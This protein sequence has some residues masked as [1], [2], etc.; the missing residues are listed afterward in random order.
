MLK[1]DHSF[2]APNF[3]GQ[4]IALTMCVRCVLWWLPWLRLPVRRPHSVCWCTPA[5]TDNALSGSSRTL[6]GELLTGPSSSRGQRRDPA[7]SRVLMQFGSDESG[8]SHQLSVFPLRLLLEAAGFNLDDAGACGR[9]ACFALLTVPIGLLTSCGCGCGCAA[10]SEAVSDLTLRR[11]GLF[12]CTL[13][14]ALAVCLV[15]SAL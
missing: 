3:F 10:D 13:Q 4:S 8:D 6:R 12:L 9:T 14:A 15:L 11:Q 2:E 7:Q 1:I 5:G